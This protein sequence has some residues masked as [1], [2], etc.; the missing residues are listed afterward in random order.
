M[1]KY[2]STINHLKKPKNTSKMVKVFSNE[3]KESNDGNNY[4]IKNTDTPDGNRVETDT[5]NAC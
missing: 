4:N 3:F 1:N 2:P 5:P